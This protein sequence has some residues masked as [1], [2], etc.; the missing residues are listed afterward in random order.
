MFMEVG[1]EVECGGMMDL[2]SESK[3]YKGPVG[4]G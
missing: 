4:S 2:I 1:D 3:P